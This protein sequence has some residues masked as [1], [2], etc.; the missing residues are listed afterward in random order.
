MKPAVQYELYTYVL[1]VYKC[2]VTA[3]VCIF[4]FIPLEFSLMAEICG[5][6]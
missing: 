2:H 6:F 3:C 1:Q 5:K 4:F